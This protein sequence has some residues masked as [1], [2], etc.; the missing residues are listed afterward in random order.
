MLRLIALNNANN[1][2]VYY[3]A[4]RMNPKDGHNEYQLGVCSLTTYRPY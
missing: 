3:Y 4:V 1:D 2:G